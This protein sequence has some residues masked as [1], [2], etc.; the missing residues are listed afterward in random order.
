MK[1]IKKPI[2]SSLIAMMFTLIL[3][4]SLANNTGTTKLS[5]IENVNIDI[6]KQ[7][8]AKRHNQERAK[9]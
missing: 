2:K 1:S 8:W 7:E 6:V 5:T 4:L 9:Y 3:G